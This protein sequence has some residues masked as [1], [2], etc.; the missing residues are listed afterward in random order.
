MSLFQE[1]R[2]RHVV[3]RLAGESWAPKASERSE[4]PDRCGTSSD[5]QGARVRA[6]RPAMIGAVAQ[7]VRDRAMASGES[8]HTRIKSATYP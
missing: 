7:N 8:A 4:S 5:Q 3:A 6:S 2:G 1:D